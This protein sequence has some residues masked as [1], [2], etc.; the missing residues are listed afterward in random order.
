MSDVARPEPAG[1]P[2]FDEAPASPP[3][4]PRRERLGRHA[5]RARLYA[6]AVV[7]VAVLTIVVAL[8][9]ANLRSVKLDWIVGSTHA[10]LFWVVL[11]A[12]ILGWV[13][14]MVTSILFRYRTRRTA[15][16]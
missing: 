2:G 11:V 8:A 5:R 15:S 16:S 12:S 9:A 14:G 6:T 10:S 3:G 1:E 4:E 13:L 7:L